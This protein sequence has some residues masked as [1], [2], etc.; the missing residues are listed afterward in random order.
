MRTTFLDAPR[1]ECSHSVVTT[2]PTVPE[3]VR[4]AALV[5]VASTLQR[6]PAYLSACAAQ[7]RG[8]GEWMYAAQ[9]AAMIA[10]LSTEVDRTPEDVDTEAVAAVPRQ[11]AAA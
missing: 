6:H 11:A 1:D 7:A 3:Q 10:V 5:T 4:S 9:I 8:R 2:R